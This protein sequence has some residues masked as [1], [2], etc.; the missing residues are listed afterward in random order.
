MDRLD[1]TMPEGPAIDDPTP[2]EIAER[3]LLIQDGWTARVRISRLYGDSER[4][5]RNDNWELG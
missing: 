2:E 5:R 1:P 3:C 4:G